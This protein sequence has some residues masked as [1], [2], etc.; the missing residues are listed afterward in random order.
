MTTIRPFRPTGDRDRSERTNEIRE[1]GAAMASGFTLPVNREAEEGLIGWLLDFSYR[2]GDVRAILTGGAQDFRVDDC[3]KFYA[4]MEAL[5]DAGKTIDA[6]TVAHQLGDSSEETWGR[7]TTLRQLAPTG[8]D[9]GL[10]YAGVVRDLAQRRNDI[11]LS[12]R[13]TQAAQRES[14]DSYV[15][16]RASLLDALAYN[17]SDETSSPF[18]PRRLSELRG[19]PRPAMVDPEMRL[20]EH[21]LALIFAEPNTGKSAYLLWR[22]CVLAQSG[23]N[24]VYLAGEGQA[25][26]PDRLDAAICV[27]RLDPAQIERH[28]RIIEQTPQLLNP[29]EVRA[30]IRQL[31]DAFDDGEPIALV[32]LDTLSTATEGQ[33]ENDNAVMSG[34]AGGMRRIMSAFNCAGII[35]H[36]PG[37][38]ATREGMGRIRGGSSLPGTLD[39]AIELRREKDSD[40]LVAECQKARDGSNLWKEAY[41]LHVQPLDDPNDPE[42]A[43]VTVMIGAEM[44]ES[45]IHAPRQRGLNP[46]QRKMLDVLGSL[47][48]GMRHGAWIAQA[49]QMHGIKLDTAKKCIAKLRDDLKLVYIDDDGMYHVAE[50]TQPDSLG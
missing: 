25:G 1:S 7:L 30:V 2:I 22:L 24:V 41:T 13:L 12:E 39:L 19:R 40:V 16:T 6:V 14:T 23:R 47:S 27:H 43:S 11:V 20:K 21:Q 15:V 3:R 50:T 17:I 32:A 4:A 8:P 34:A 49:E 46:T 38:D 31:E 5:D 33:N 44:P 37:K 9:D 42:A 45:V 36:H 35:T 10:D 48:C 29:S 26:I 18:Q 28:L